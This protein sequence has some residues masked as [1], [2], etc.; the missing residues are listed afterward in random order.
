MG[1]VRGDEPIDLGQGEAGPTLARIARPSS[2]GRVN[3]SQWPVGRSTWVTS[4]IFA[5]SR[6]G[7]S[8]RSTHPRSISLVNSVATTVTGTS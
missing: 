3:C 7:A 6:T 2:S 4:R 8:P 5:S 1:S